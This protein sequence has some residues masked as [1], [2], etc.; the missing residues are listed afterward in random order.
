M[1][2][3]A[4]ACAFVSIAAPSTRVSILLYRRQVLNECETRHVPVTQNLNIIEFWPTSAR[5]ATGTRR[6]CPPIR[7]IQNGILVTRSR[8]PVVDRP[9][10]RSGQ[11]VLQR[12][13][14]PPRHSAVTRPQNQGQAR[15]CDAGGQG[16]HRLGWR[17]RSTPCSTPYWRKNRAKGPAV[18]HTISD[19][20]MDYDLAFMA[21]FITRLPN[22]SFS[23]RAA[24]E[25]DGG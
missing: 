15:V 6:A 23:P 9:Q 24:G 14:G 19:K 5:S 21:Y 12:K 11:L 25:D 7:Y 20:Q 1:G 22:P 16:L 3:C 8:F 10:R 18:H 4:V 13:E 17:T 2:D